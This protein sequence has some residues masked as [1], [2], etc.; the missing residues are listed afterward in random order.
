[1]GSIGGGDGDGRLGY[2]IV[3]FDVLGIKRLRFGDGV[4]AVDRLYAI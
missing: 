4:V 2:C 3:N 1:V